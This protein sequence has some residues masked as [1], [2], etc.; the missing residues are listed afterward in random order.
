MKKQDLGN[1]R[2]WGSLFTLRGF[3]N[4]ELRMS[5]LGSQE[6]DGEIGRCHIC[7]QTFATQEE[8]SKHL[9]E[10]HGGDEPTTDPG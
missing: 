9:I 3:W 10:A 8:L 6:G 5:G 2:R 1:P 7:A 4:E